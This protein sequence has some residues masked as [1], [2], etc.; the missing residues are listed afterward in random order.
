MMALSRETLLEGPLLLIPP[1]PVC[2]AAVSLHHLFHPLSDVG[3]RSGLSVG[4]TSNNTTDLVDYTVDQ[5]G[6]F[7][8]SSPIKVSAQQPAVLTTAV[9]PIKAHFADLLSA[10]PKTD[11]EKLLMN[12]R[13]RRRHDNTLRKREEGIYLARH[14]AQLWGECEIIHMRPKENF[15]EFL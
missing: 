8:H 15:G 12:C 10:D 5:L 1:T 3:Q 11:Q 4:P 9:S 13:K 14:P 6:H 7:A 2:T